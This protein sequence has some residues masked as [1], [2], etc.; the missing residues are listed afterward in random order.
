ME[1]KP[2]T[3][4]V[5]EEEED[6]CIIYQRVEDQEGKDIF[7][8]YNLDQCPEDAIIGRELFTAQQFLRAVQLGMNLAA[9]GYNCVRTE[10]AEDE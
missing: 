4:K 7:V 2:Y 1:D 5:Y 6:Y 3:F 10:Y 9:Q 8:A